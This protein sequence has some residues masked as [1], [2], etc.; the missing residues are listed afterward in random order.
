MRPQFF[1]EDHKYID[2]S[3]KEYTPVT[4]ICAITP[5]GVDFSSIPYQDRIKAAAQRGTVRHKELEELIKYWTNEEN[6]LDEF[7]PAF[8]T[9]EWFMQNLL[10]NERYDQWS[11][12]EIVFSDEPTTSFAGSIDLVCRDMKTER[13]ILWDLKTGGHS[14]VDYQL[15]LYKRAFCKNY[16][17][18]PN[19]VELRC[20]DAKDEDKIKVLNIRTI[21]Q[22]WLDKL[23]DCYEKKIPYI[24]SAIVLKTMSNTSLQRLES[25]ES[26][27]SALNAEIEAL[28]AERDALKTSLYNA[29][30]KEQ[31]K[32]FTYG[33]LRASLVEPVRE[34]VFDEKGCKEKYT[35]L[36]WDSYTKE[37]VTKVFDKEAFQ[38]DH[39]KEFVE[40]V[41]EQQKKK[42]YIR[43]SVKDVT[44]VESEV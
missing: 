20:I 42:G 8:K 23:L 32:N 29:M 38:K 39:P 1:P 27:V 9:T 11:S 14:T 19:Q 33:S 17:E 13:W 5:R 18:D 41:K 36:P 22:D 44:E 28:T 4:R 34:F 30:S 7:I 21:P 31:M 40:F 37:V 26:Y 35:D 25:F 16:K 15:S 6:D 24:E 12:E 10:S 2:A 43:L 3:G